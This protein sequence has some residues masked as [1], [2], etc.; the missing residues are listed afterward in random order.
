MQTQ[1][2]TIEKGGLLIGENREIVEVEK[3]TKLSPNNQE[4]QPKSKAS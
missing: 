3:V 1:Q 2:L 4:N